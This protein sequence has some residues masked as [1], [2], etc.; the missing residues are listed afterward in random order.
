MPH[1]TD[2][3]ALTVRWVDVEVDE[4][5]RGGN[6][7]RRKN[8]HDRGRSVKSAWVQGR[9]LRG[10]I[11]HCN[12]RLY[13]WAHKREDVSVGPAKRGNADESDVRQ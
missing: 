1:K 4:A 9:I 2:R 10:W 3:R 12:G 5:T 8:L 7:P 11:R 13:D 6:V